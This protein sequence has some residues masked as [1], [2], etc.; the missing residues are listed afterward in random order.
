VSLVLYCVAVPMYVCIESMMFRGTKM[1]VMC[2]LFVNVV[3]EKEMSIRIHVETLTHFVVLLK[4][5]TQ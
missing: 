5:E 2:G 4:Y 3:D 1:S